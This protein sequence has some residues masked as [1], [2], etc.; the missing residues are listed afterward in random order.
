MT[1]ATASRH[2]ANKGIKGL[3]NKRTRTSVL[4]VLVL[5]AF[6]ACAP[7]WWLVVSVTKTRVDLYNTNGL[8][9]GH[10]NNLIQNFQQLFQY[11]NGL[12]FKWMWNSILYAGLGSLVCMV[13]SLAAG[14]SLS[15]Y[16]YPGR[17]LGMGLVMCSFLIPAALLTMPMYLMFSAVHMTDTIWAVLVPFF[18]NAFDVYLAKVYIDGS[19]PDELLEAARVDGAGEF[20]IFSKIVLPLLSTPAATIFIL[21]F[22]LNWNNFYLPIVMLRG[23]DKW[24]LSLGLY[25]F[26]QTKQNALFDP[27]T[28]ALAGAVLS[29]V[30]L[31]VVMIAM[32]RYWKSG[33][34]LGSVKG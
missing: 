26:M 1:S 22:V 28:I 5:M 13:I 14:Y 34:A 17:S 3:S 15:K 12:F 7:L 2:G 30:P 9:F 23:S 20:Y 4:V 8:W 16:K 6:Y 21:T 18:I 33:V 24:T 10:S 11:E 19:V 25:S 31:A 32:Q 29:I 27:T